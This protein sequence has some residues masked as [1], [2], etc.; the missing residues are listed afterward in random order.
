MRTRNRLRTQRD[1]LRSALC[2]CVCMLFRVCSFDRQQ[3]N[4]VWWWLEVVRNSFNVGCI[5]R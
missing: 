3:L 4:D 1:R 2:L 5:A